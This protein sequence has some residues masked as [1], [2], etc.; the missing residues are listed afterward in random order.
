MGYLNGAGETSSEAVKSDMPVTLSS[1]RV[2]LTV[3][4]RNVADAGEGAANVC[5]L[6]PSPVSR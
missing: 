5:L 1:R 2:S 4:S 6:S 3:P